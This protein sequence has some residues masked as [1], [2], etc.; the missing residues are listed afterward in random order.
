MAWGRIL[1]NRENM[2]FIVPF[3]GVLWKIVIE[4]LLLRNY[5][6]KLTWIT[7]SRPYNW[8]F[9]VNL[10]HCIFLKAIHSDC[11]AFHTVITGFGP[12]VFFTLQATFLSRF[13]Q[14]INILVTNFWNL[15]NITEKP[16]SHELGVGR[17]A[18]EKT[19]RDPAIDRESSYKWRIADRLA[20]ESMNGKINIR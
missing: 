17:N 7:P 10:P 8:C 16:I 15:T 9:R 5:L 18:I 1:N 3:I 12:A 4:Y 19:Y 14:K 13:L 11:N 2:V 20:N 6:I